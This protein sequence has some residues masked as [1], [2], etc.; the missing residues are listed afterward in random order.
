MI[1]K[2]S[3]KFFSVPG[4]LYFPIIA[5]VGTLFFIWVIIGETSSEQCSPFVIF[6]SVSW[7]VFEIVMLKITAPYA[8]SVVEIRNDSVVCRIPFYKN[9]VIEYDKCFIGFDYHNQNGGKIWWIYLCYGQMP[10]YKNSQ[11][12]N[13]INSLKCQPGFVRIMYRDKVYEALMEVIP[14]KQ[15]T[16]LESARRYSGFEKQGRII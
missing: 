3:K 6:F 11:L 9:V 10:P 2:T 1:G 16:A 15:K 4:G 8:M 5:I 13:R 7:I 12:G 14:Q